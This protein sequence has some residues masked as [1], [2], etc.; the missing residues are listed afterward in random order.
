MAA[1]AMIAV[2]VMHFVS[3]EGFAKIVPAIKKMNL[4]S[5]R[6]RKNFQELG[7]LQFE[8]WGDPFEDLEKSPGGAVSARL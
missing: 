5:D 6:Q 4:L 7:I 8:N 2:G 3:A 1:G